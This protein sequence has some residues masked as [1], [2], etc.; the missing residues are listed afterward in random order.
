MVTFL[1]FQVLFPQLTLGF[2]L[3]HFDTQPHIV[4]IR[5]DVMCAI[6][7]LLKDH[8]AHL[9]LSAYDPVAEVVSHP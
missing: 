3:T 6:M 7:N 4:T 1:L 9:H 5:S 2:Y 8:E